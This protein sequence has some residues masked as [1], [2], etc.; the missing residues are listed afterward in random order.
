M[1]TMEAAFAA[2]FPC[3]ARNRGITKSQSGV[4]M[5]LCP[6]LAWT[7]AKGSKCSYVS[8][9]SVVLGWEDSFFMA[10]RNGMFDTVA[11]SIFC[12]R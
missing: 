5:T 4:R 10:C 6:G 2:R 7:K 3:L 12:S 8:T 9:S 11:E 1:P